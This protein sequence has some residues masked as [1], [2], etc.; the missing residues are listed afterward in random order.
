MAQLDPEMDTTKL[1]KEENTVIYQSLIGAIQ[2]SVSL[3]RF[4]IATAVMTLSSFTAAPRQGH[5]DRLNRLYG[6]LTEQER[7][8]KTFPR[9]AYPICDEPHVRSQREPR[10]QS[11]GEIDPSGWTDGET[12]TDGPMGRRLQRSLLVRRQLQGPLTD[13]ETN[14]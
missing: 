7:M 4:D 2:W 13:G 8:V 14:P 1:L 11:K 12:E 10:T 9:W 3:G 5:L 6:Y